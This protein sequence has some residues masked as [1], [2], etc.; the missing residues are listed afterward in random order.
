ML[1]FIKVKDFRQQ[2]RVTHPRSVFLSNVI[3]INK[4]FILVL[5]FLLRIMLLNKE[6][7][8]TD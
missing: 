8:E 1:E 3:R 7:C 2:Q 6:G 5:L 4:D